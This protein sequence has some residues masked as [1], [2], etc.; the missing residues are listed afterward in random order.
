MLLE[1]YETEASMLHD[2][3]ILDSSE[4]DVDTGA[5]DANTTSNTTTETEPR[6]AFEELARP[7]PSTKFYT[8]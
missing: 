4:V 5:T 3:Q 6:E 1:E 2:S 7:K 8:T